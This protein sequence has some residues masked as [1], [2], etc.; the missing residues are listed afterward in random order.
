[1]N[2][3]PARLVRMLASLTKIQVSAAN[4]V[5]GL[6]G[7]AACG[8]VL[9]SRAAIFFCAIFL[10]SSGASVL[11]NI[12]DRA[13]DLKMERTKHRPIPGKKISRAGAMM[14]S[15]SMIA[16]GLYGLFLCS[17]ST[18]PVIC[19]IAAVLLYNG[20]YTPLRKKTGTAVLYGVLCGMSPPFIGW[21]AAGGAPDS[22]RIWY[23]MVLLG[24][25][26]IPHYL[27]ILL[28]NRDDYTRSGLPTVLNR[29][30]IN[31]LRVLAYIWCFGYGVVTMNAYFFGLP[32]ALPF[33]TALFVN[34]VAVCLLATFV[35]LGR[36]SEKKQR[37]LFYYLNL[38]IM[39]TSTAIILDSFL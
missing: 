4:S 3:G 15:A 29:I 38:S 30:T 32:D 5:A 36:A 2:T 14:I 19:G 8:T 9:S 35:L 16:A 1:M 12:Q 31:E 7:Y 26:Q 27:L 25:W 18:A 13:L 22:P 34:A 21:L 11:N 20:I 6:L 37:I 28:N 24:T 39:G 33:I 10:L 23:L 17:P